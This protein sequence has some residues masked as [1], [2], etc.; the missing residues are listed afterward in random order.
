MNTPPYFIQK[1][2][3]GKQYIT[4]CTVSFHFSKRLHVFFIVTSQYTLKQQV[5][6]EPTWIKYWAVLE[7][8]DYSIA[9]YLWTSPQKP[10]PLTAWTASDRIGQRVCLPVPSYS[11]LSPL[12]KD[13]YG[14][15]LVRLQEVHGSHKLKVVVFSLDEV[16]NVA[17]SLSSPCSSYREIKI[18]I[19]SG[20]V[21]FTL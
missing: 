16:P 17:H 18:F 7:Q 19:F 21:Q 3:K 8:R 6:V 14:E 2:S 5:I 12:A 10:I 20:V 11:T 1:L 4:R 9:V 15:N 13:T